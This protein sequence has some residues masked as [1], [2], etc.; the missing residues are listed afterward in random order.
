MEMCPDRGKVP[1]ETTP[2]K[3]NSRRGRK[4]QGLLGGVVQGGSFG[5]A[6][7]GVQQRGP[8]FLSVGGAKKL[9]LTNPQRKR[10]E[11]SEV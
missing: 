5:A 2:F 11:I 6:H 7:P 4:G 10:K 3:E 9:N 8:C 1:G